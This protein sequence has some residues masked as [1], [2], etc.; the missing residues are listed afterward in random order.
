MPVDS[1]KSNDFEKSLPKISVFGVGGAG[2]NAVNNMILSQLDSVKFVVANTDCQS[3]ANSLAETKIQLGSKCTKGLG[4]GSNPDVGRQAAEEAIDIIKHELCG[5]DML[6]IATG[7]GG[8]TGTGASPV[9]AKMANDMG[10]LTVVIAIKP[11]QLEGRKRR[12]VADKGIVEL[13]KVADTMIVIDNQK[14]MS[15]NNVS[16]FENYTIADSILR[17]AVYCVVSIL[18]KQGF[19]NRDFADIKTIL[20][21][22]GR[23]IIGYG[24]SQDAIVAT[25]SAIRNQVLENTS[26]RGARNILVNITGNRSLKSAD[27]E[28][29]VNKVRNDA[30][31]DENDEPN[32]I[33][34]VVFDD[35]L[36][37]NIRVS[38]IASGLSSDSNGIEDTTNETNR[39]SVNNEYLGASD[40]IRMKKE[41]SINKAEFNRFGDEV[42]EIRPGRDKTKQESMS[43]IDEMSKNNK[44]MNDYDDSNVD[45]EYNFENE[46]DNI[47]VNDINTNNNDNDNLCNS[48]N[49]A[50]EGRNDKTMQF[51]EDDIEL[52]DSFNLNTKSI[53]SFTTMNRANNSQFNSFPE[54]KKKNSFYQERLVHAKQRQKKDEY[55]IREE[56]G[57]LFANRETKKKSFFS[58]LVNSIAPTP[59]IE[60]SNMDD[61]F[62]DSKN[63][64]NTGD[65]EENIYRVSAIKRKIS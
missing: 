9:I 30:K 60:S 59:F 50:Y 7:L 18:V 64:D 24:E 27:I 38:V 1:N 45:D 29:V 23:A 43:I 22:S 58:K 40:A 56:E 15:M 49:L 35:E 34:G 54:R 57:S 12:E 8:G 46:Y 28:S 52:D 19:I 4:A 32:V 14:L 31:C 44:A 17:Q 53:Q 48:D 3:L 10:I 21:S 65:E 47:N 25:D 63:D 2:V 37:D 41:N 26:I 33:F 13:E 55:N 62:D 20:S 51:N 42:D 6:F 39:E 36:G 61:V 5:T 16:M 11:F